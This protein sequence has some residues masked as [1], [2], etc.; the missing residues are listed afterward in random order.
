MIC[1]EM[2]MPLQIATSGGDASL[3]GVAIACGQREGFFA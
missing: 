1:R 3:A 2:S